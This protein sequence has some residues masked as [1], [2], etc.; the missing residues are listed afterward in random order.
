MAAKPRRLTVAQVIAL[1]GAATGLLEV[2]NHPL[3]TLHH[4]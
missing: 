2:L 4:W 1:I 3:E